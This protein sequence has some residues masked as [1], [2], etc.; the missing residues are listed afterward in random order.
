MCINISMSESAVSLSETSWSYVDGD[1]VEWER[2]RR[3]SNGAIVDVCMRINCSLRFW[4]KKRSRFYAQVECECN[5]A[6]ADN[7]VACLNV[8]LSGQLVHNVHAS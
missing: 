8:L 6:V 5:S 7:A 3:T 1:H 2:K 4:K